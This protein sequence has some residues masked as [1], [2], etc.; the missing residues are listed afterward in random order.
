ML[1]SW[2]SHPPLVQPGMIKF[3]AATHCWASRGTIHRSQCEQWPL[4]SFNEKHFSDQWA[5]LNIPARC[6]PDFNR[7]NHLRWG[8]LSLGKCGC[9]LS[10][11]FSFVFPATFFLLLKQCL[12]SRD[13]VSPG[14][15]LSFFLSQL[16]NSLCVGLRVSRSRYIS[17]LVEGERAGQIEARDANN[18]S[19]ERTLTLREDSGWL[20]RIPW[21]CSGWI[22][23][24]RSI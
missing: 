14:F 22:A 9:V 19:G 17:I 21:P 7:K 2:P 11:C 18:P 4:E 5:S 6:M 8:A 3:R 12:C 23:A 10:I 24:A 15:S 16:C 1:P 13:P 20:S